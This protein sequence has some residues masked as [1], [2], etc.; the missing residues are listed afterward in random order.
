MPSKTGSGGHIVPY[1]APA[2]VHNAANSPDNDVENAI[3]WTETE[4]CE[5]AVAYDSEDFVHLDCSLSGGYRRPS[6]AASGPRSLGL[7]GPIDDHVNHRLS[8]RERHLMHAEERQ[9][10]LD[11]HCIGPREDRSGGEGNAIQQAGER[12]L[13]SFPKLSG[14]KVVEEPTTP[15]NLPSANEQS[16]LLGRQEENLESNDSESI[17]KR[18]E[19][20]VAE[21]KI[22]TTWQRETQVLWQYS[23]SLILTFMLQY[24]LPMTS[25]FTLG[26]KGKIELGAVSLGTMTANIT[27]YCVFQGLATSLD[28]LCPQ[29]Y[30]AGKKKL[31]GLHTQRMFFFLLCVTIPIG[32]IWLSATHI[33][34]LIVPERE[35]A[36]LA[37]L[38]LKV[39]LFGTPA[40]AAF[41]SGK[42]FV[43]AQ[44]LFSA[45]L[46]VLL[47]CAP[48]NVLLNWLL[49]WKLDWGFIGAPIA[50]VFIQYCLALC[51]FLYVRFVNGMECWGGFDRRAF[52][53][54]WPMVKLAIPGL[55]ML[56]AEMLAFE[57]LTLA[58]SWFGSTELASQ[59]VLS[60]MAAFAFQLPFP[61]SISASTRVANLIGATLVD[62]AKTA[63]K[64]SLV[65]AAVVGCFNMVML[66]LL[67][68]YIPKLFTNDPDVTSLVS[69]VLPV[70]AAFQ[71]FDA[72]ATMCSG[73]LR[74]LGRQD[75]GG[76]V[77]LVAYYVIAIPISFGLGFGFSLGLP[78]LWIGPAIALAVVAI[79]EGIFLYCSNWQRSVDD[80]KRR[81]AS[82]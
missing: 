45:T 15:K 53:N 44:A 29:A 38:Y 4:G 35:T 71:L 66:S 76:Y 17:D 32:A 46:W 62:A 11:N 22:T 80:A 60:T 79:V 50:V 3:E 59:S 58:A 37:G 8:E 52:A 67:R 68:E 49:V 23:R 48:L 64:V 10:L 2:T 20:A 25:I 69:H 36:E 21:G 5:D 18:W 19:E 65:A 1:E 57:I 12:F 16:P 81:N 78:G 40:Y 74:G 34:K 6:M 43:Q 27:G 26:R 61:L 42:R 77:N 55:I 33:L 31:V 30:G 13:Q 7:G 24:S 63:A 75:V 39:V 70:C 82:H 56:V 72:V 73:L 28:T 54:W 51:L 14:I 41:E 9:L 47:I